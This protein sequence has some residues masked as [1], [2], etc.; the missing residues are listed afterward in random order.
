MAKSI[1]AIVTPE[2]LSI[3]PCHK[4]RLSPSNTV[5][6]LRFFICLIRPKKQNVLRLPYPVADSEDLK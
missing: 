1:P 4:Q 2:V 6:L 3:Q 5:C